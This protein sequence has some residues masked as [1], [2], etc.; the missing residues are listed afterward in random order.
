[1]G[2]TFFVSLCAFN[3][4]LT[5]FRRF[6]WFVASY[7]VQENWLYISILLKKRLLHKVKKFGNCNLPPSPILNKWCMIAKNFIINMFASRNL[8]KWNYFKVLWWRT[9][10]R[11]L[12]S[13]HK[14]KRPIKG[15]LMPSKFIWKINQGRSIRF[16]LISTWLMSRVRDARNLILFG[17]F[18]SHGL[19]LLH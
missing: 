10:R 1:M 6:S 8:S 7:L 3:P 15:Q 4:L 2:R 16:T 18:I 13:S 11:L 19:R 17:C 5:S 14:R 9:K 12:P